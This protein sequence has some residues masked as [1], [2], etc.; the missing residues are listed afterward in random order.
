VFTLEEVRG[1]IAFYKTPAGQGFLD[2]QPL[3]MQK[4]MA[5][6]QRR[7][8]DLTPKIQEMIKQESQPTG[9]GTQ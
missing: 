2:K 5:M 4:T 6:A 8:M 1:L 9:K 3:L 7:M